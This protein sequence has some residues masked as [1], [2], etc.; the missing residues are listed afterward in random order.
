MAA[1]RS[2]EL[3]GRTPGRTS[4]HRHSSRPLCEFRWTI[5][6]VKHPKE[7]SKYTI[8][9]LLLFCQIYYYRYK[10]HRLSSCDSEE[11]ERAALIPNQRGPPHEE[12][13]PGKILVIRYAC[14]LAFVVIVGVAAWWISEKGND[15]DADLDNP[16]EG[17][18]KWWA[19]QVLG[20]SSALLFVCAQP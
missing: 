8:C 4:T 3:G 7:Y 12:A 20:W 13:L 9:D 16:M 6:K 17:S 11:Q 1:R 2:D 18:K 14:A 5:S 19:I 15:D 10:R